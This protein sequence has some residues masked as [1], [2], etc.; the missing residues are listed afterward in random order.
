MVSVA[1]S[2]DA[3]SKPTKPCTNGF[4]LPLPEVL[5]DFAREKFDDSGNLTDPET[6]E[7]IRDLLV[8][9]AAWTHR[10]GQSGDATVAS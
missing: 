3:L 5:V 2:P 1:P 7:E 4:V 10:L 6:R 8:S 9:L